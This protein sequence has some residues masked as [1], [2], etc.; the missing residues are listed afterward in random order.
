MGNTIKLGDIVYND[1][2][3]EVYVR[4]FDKTKIENKNSFYMICPKCLRMEGCFVQIHRPL[5]GKPYIKN[6]CKIC[7]HTEILGV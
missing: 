6:T 4:D 2:T 3:E 1:E 7:S 5:F